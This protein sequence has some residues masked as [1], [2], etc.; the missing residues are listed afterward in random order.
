MTSA[1]VSVIAANLVLDARDVETGGKEEAAGR[2]AKVAHRSA[3]Q[4]ARESSPRAFD[5]NLDEGQT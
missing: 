1:A 5:M 4:G 2:A 3:R